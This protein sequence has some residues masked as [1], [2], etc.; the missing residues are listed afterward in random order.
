MRAQA[1]DIYHILFSKQAFICFFVHA[2]MLKGSKAQNPCGDLLKP[3][4]HFEREW[5]RFPHYYSCAPSSCANCMTTP[6]PSVSVNS[7]MTR[8]NFLLNFFV[9]NV[10]FFSG[11]FILQL[12]PT[13]LLIYPCLFLFLTLKLLIFIF[14]PHIF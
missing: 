10:N 11:F 2:Y 7:C 4:R 6:L 8:V 3:L 12:E 14:G 5:R 9:Y 13:F 1:Y